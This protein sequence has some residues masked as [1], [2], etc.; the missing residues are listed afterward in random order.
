MLA[1]T[2]CVALY[3]PYIV[4]LMSIIGGAFGVNTDYIIPSTPHTYIYI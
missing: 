3:F 1:A 4:S 2:T